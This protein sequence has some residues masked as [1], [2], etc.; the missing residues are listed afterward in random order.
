MRCS[1]PEPVAVVTAVA[2]ALAL[3]AGRGRGTVWVVLAIL[4]GQLYVGWSN[5][6]LDRNRDRIAGRRDK[7]I[8]ADRIGAR[9]VG[10]SALIALVA[11]VALSFASGAVAALVHVAALASASAYNLGLKRTLFSALPYAFSFAMVPAFVTLGLPHSH[12]PPAW[13]MAAAALIG[14]G[15]HFAQSRPDVVADRL[16]GDIGLPQ[17]AGDRA[18]AVLAAVFLAVGAAVIAAGTRSLVPLIAVVPVPAVVLAPPT[19]AYRL[20]L[21]IAVFAVGAFLL[22]GGSLAG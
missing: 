11:A 19:A 16:Q 5:D 22:N 17:L 21:L 12:W 13:V 18:S 9:T 14:V 1:H 3:T 2:G 4:A 6:Y 7:P 20:T 8:A 15:G 10:V